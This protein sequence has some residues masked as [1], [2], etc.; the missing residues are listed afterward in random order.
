MLVNRVSDTFLFISVMLMWWYLGTTDYTIFLFNTKEAYYLDWICLTMMLGAAG[1]SAQIGL[2][3]WLADAMEGWCQTEPRRY[4]NSKMFKEFNATFNNVINRKFVHMGNLLFIRNYSKNSKNTYNITK[5]QWNNLL[6]IVLG[7]I[8]GGHPIRPP[9][10]YIPSYI[11]FRH[12]NKQILEIIFKQMVFLL[13]E[14]SQIGLRHNFNYFYSKPLSEITSLFNL[15]Y[16]KDI[17]NIT[18]R[19]DNWVRN[20]NFL[21]NDLFIKFFNNQTLVFWFLLCGIYNNQYKTVVFNID[22][23]TEKELLHLSNLIENKCNIKTVVRLHITKTKTKYYLYIN[24]E[25]LN[26]FI[27]LIN[28]YYDS[29]L[30]I[31]KPSVIYIPGSK[32]SSILVGLMLGDGS[33]SL[34]K[35][36]TGA[37]RYEHTCKHRDFLVN[38]SEQW[39][40]LYFEKSIPTPWPQ[41]SPTQW[42]RG[43]KMLPELFDLYKLWYK[44]DP[45][46]KKVKIIPL[47]LVEN[48]FNEISLAHWFMDDGYFDNYSGTFRFCT[49]NFTFTECEFLVQLLEQKC[50]IKATTNVRR[51]N[52]WRIRVSMHS[53]PL[54]RQLVKPYLLPIF[55]YKLG[56]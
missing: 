17:L 8:L 41:E 39:L 3:T 44:R 9:S 36:V 22:Y 13:R 4:N 27:G 15:C 53:V 47:N 19:K 33:I 26:D 5:T 40:P 18:R 16:K 14:N 37:A 7:C 34:S 54:F 50:N 20:D 51:K 12:T 30:I 49:D 23:Y 24:N 31:K 6:P 45:K 25:S 29:D 35:G 28:T 52:M 11:I 46:G 55:H 1:K 10:I 21:F 38:L 56:E 48:D 42:W 32:E 2:H 43:S